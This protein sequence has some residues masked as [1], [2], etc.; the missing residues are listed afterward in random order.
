MK[1]FSII[2]LLV[3]TACTPHL[4]T[5]EA[6]GPPIPRIQPKMVPP[7]VSLLPTITPD[8]RENK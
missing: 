1:L 3:F 2:C 8:M 5:P 6:S 4:I 7:T